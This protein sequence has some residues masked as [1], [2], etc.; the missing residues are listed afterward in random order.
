MKNPFFLL[1]ALV[2][3]RFL[4]TASAGVKDFA[5]DDSTSYKKVVDVIPMTSVVDDY[6]D[7]SF[8]LNG[9]LSCGVASKIIFNLI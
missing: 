2:M 7:G 5:D 8:S 6:S 3:T 4:I 1:L 9:V